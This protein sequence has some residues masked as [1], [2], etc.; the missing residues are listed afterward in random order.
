MILLY[1][2]IGDL[3]LSLTMGEDMMVDR[4]RVLQAR[5]IA[6]EALAS[7]LRGMVRNSDRL[8]KCEDLINR[9]DVILPPAL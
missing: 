4:E 8:H 5:W 6:E 7:Q 1:V 9:L 2:F 3:D